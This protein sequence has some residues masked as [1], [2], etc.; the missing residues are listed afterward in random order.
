MKSLKYTKINNAPNILSIDLDNGYSV[1]AIHGH[2]KNI[3]QFEVSL[4]IKDNEFTTWR[5]VGAAEKLFFNG[6]FKTINS[7]ILRE[8]QALNEDKFFDYYIEQYQFEENCLSS[9]IEIQ[10]RKRE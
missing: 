4:F 8:I 9:I 10:E 5:M 7:I 6:D 2:N 3:N 1:I